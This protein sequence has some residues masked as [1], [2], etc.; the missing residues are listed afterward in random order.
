MRKTRLACALL[1]ITTF[2]A[3]LAGP[4]QLNRTVDDWDAKTY[5]DSPWL[6]G[7]ASQGAVY[8]G[9]GSE[10]DYTGVDA[11]RDLRRQSRWR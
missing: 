9:A 3:C 1:A 7:K 4:H 6:D 5:V 11:T 10:A 8:V 2:A